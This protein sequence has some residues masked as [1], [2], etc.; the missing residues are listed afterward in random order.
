MTRCGSILALSVIVMLCPVTVSHAQETEANAVADAAVADVRTQMRTP[1][2]MRVADDSARAELFRCEPRLPSSCR[3]VGASAIIQAYGPKVTGD[4]AV[5]DVVTWESTDSERRPIY[6]VTRR[7][8]LRKLD[9]RWTVTSRE[10]R[11]V[12]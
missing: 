5:V 9:G 12:T 10:I 2:A 11:S 4:V 8:T 1:D 3:I 7:L 6:R